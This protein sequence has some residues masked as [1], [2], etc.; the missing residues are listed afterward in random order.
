L[1]FKKSKRKTFF[2]RDQVLS[3]VSLSEIK[4]S[5]KIPLNSCIILNIY[6][7]IKGRGGFKRILKNFRFEAVQQ[8]EILNFIKKKTHNGVRKRKK[9]RK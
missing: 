9:R 4:E 1:Y 3:K 5:K 2:A 6:G 8:H 7:P